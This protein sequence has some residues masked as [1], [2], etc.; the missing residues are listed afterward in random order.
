[1]KESF[2]KYLI[3]ELKLKA[4]YADLKDSITRRQQ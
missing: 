3:E 2:P 1:M 4:D